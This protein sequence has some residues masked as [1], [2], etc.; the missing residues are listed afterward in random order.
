M[1]RLSKA[2]QIKKAKERL[3]VCEVQAL[4]PSFP[5]GHVIDHEE[6]DFLIE[7]P[8]DT[9]GLEVVDYIRGQTKD[10]A[11][12]E[13][14]SPLRRSEQ[15]SQRLASQARLEFERTHAEKLWVI[16]RWFGRHNIKR[17]LIDQLAS[18]LAHAV[19]EAIPDSTDQLRD[20]PDTAL[21]GLL[22]ENYLN[23]SQGGIR[24]IL[25]R[26]SAG[27]TVALV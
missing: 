15:L 18:E 1:A 22:I 23:Q 8:F 3:F 26:A 13:H 11:L 25:S 5:P 20:V 24:M 21:E 4:S 6:P 2:D 19:A 17:L 16:F 7:G 27:F 10:G 14:G 9:V 12:V